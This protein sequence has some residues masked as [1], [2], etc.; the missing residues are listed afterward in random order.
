MFGKHIISLCWHLFLISFYVDL[1]RVNMYVILKHLNAT[2]NTF[3]LTCN[4]SASI[5]NV[6]Y[7]PGSP[8]RFEFFIVSE[9]IRIHN[10]T[11]QVVKNKHHIL[12]WLALPQQALETWITFPKTTLDL[13]LFPRR[14][15][16]AIRR[17][18]VLKNRCQIW[19]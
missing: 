6:N 10:W 12:C 3:L 4:S 11:S 9:E 17:L 8:K 16:Y 1:M 15:G 5:E 18:Q 13:L 19:S 7:A 14:S 2:K